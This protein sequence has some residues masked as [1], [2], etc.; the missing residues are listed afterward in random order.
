[1]DPF[2]L[3]CYRSIPIVRNMTDRCNEFIAGNQRRHSSRNAAKTVN[4]R[5]AIHCGQCKMHGFVKK[6][7]ASH[8]TVFFDTFIFTDHHQYIAALN[9][10][11]S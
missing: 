5:Q 3:I 11:I 9:S 4:K 8:L 2:R 10:V 6:D 7:Y 1:M